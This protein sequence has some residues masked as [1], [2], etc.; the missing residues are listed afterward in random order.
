MKF[1][2]QFLQFFFNKDEKE[3][4]MDLTKLETE[5]SE[6]D[7]DCRFAQLF[8]RVGG[9]FHYCEDE[10]EALKVLSKI[11][12]IEEIKS[13]FCCNESLREFLDVIE[14]SNT[15][16]L[17]LDNDAAFIT[18][19]YL[20]AYDGKIML[21][22]RNIGHY[23]SYRLP[24]KIIIISRVSQI[25]ENL[26]EAM[27]KVQR[28]EMVLKNLTSISADKSEL[29]GSFSNEHQIYLLLLE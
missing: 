2:N 1:F 15:S 11:V 13:I 9:M 24:K 5:V 21:S 23:H 28:K 20:I 26:N 8:T 12:K 14:V 4:E 22:H 16:I 3:Q 19:E 27:A 25:V 17:N 18:C 10:L 29:A 7:L 6:S